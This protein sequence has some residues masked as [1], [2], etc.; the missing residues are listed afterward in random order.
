MALLL[1]DCKC[2][3]TAIPNIVL[4]K[5]AFEG[6]LPSANGYISSTEVDSSWRDR[7][8]PIVI[9][10]STFTIRLRFR[11]LAEKAGFVVLESA[12]PQHM[13]M[14]LNI[15]EEIGLIVTEIEFPQMD[16]LMV[17]KQIRTRRSEIPVLVLTADNRR[18]SFVKALHLG[19][20]DYVLKPFEGE[21][22]IQRVTDLMNASRETSFQPHAEKE[23]LPALSMDFSEYL[24]KELAKAQRGQYELTVMVSRI[25]SANGNAGMP[26]GFDEL[27]QRFS[28]V[29]HDTDM[30]MC[31]DD[32]SFW[33]LLPFCGMD[34]RE[35]LHFRIKD[36]FEMY[37]QASGDRLSLRMLCRFYTYPQEIRS[38]GE[39]MTR[40]RRDS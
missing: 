18:A 30:L 20:S 29:L 1:R 31:V 10:D 26:A 36:A 23:R 8:K 11:M 15:H 38:S 32:S 39:L 2:R 7:M 25:T 27:H 35:Q 3:P 6:E 16:G 5:S 37:R 13:S 12:S 24:N 9:L 40:L 17:L 28:A 22:L 4:K 19:A 34:R 33:G 14:M 21:Y